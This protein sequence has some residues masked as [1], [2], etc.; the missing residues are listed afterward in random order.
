MLIN[1]LENSCSGCP[2]RQLSFFK[3]IHG[4]DIECLETNKRCSKLKKGQFVFNEG[5]NPLG[6]HCIQQ[7]KVKMYK[8]N[9]DGKEQIMYFAQQ[10]DFLG[11][12]ALIAEEPLAM[13]AEVMEDSV[14]CFIPQEAFFEI[15]NRNPDVTKKMMKSLCHELSVAGDKIQSMAQKSVRER[16]AETLL[17]LHDT[18]KMPGDNNDTI[19]NITLPRE[20]I[21][22]LVGTATETVIRLLS[23]LRDEKL[24]EFEGKKIRLLNLGKLKKLAVL[25]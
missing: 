16:L 25:N 1:L 3:D 2:A 24:I 21:A 12:R 15:L 5:N 14:I 4:N 9:L 11:Y 19:I 18:F 22:N 13:T 7:G 17:V 10:G 20:D 6:I 8:T 23:E